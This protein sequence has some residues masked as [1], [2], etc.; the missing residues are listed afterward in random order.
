MR[1]TSK[2]LTFI[3]QSRVQNEIAGTLKCNIVNHNF[4][5][6][7]NEINCSIYWG[8]VSQNTHSNL[9][10]LFLRSFPSLDVDSHPEKQEQSSETHEH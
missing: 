10:I 6:F 8:K 3:T 9:N 2:V 5:Y 4:G 1:F 7:K